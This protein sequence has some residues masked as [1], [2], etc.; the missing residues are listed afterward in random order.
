VSS[1][2]LGGPL[3]RASQRR[4]VVVTPGAE[5]P[6]DESEW[7]DAIV[8]LERGDI[9]LAC[10]EGRP[11]DISPGLSCS[12]RAERDDSN[13]KT[14]S[15]V[16]LRPPPGVRGQSRCGQ[17]NGAPPFGDQSLRWRDIASARSDYRS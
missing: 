3:P 14:G 11:L 16:R 4:V 9:E 6:Y 12:R 10:T 17:R 2:L 13:A 5:L 15:A 8:V 1:C 7:H